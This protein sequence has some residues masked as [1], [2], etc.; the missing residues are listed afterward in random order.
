M[1]KLICFLGITLL[2]TLITACGSNKGDDKGPEEI[3]VKWVN[4]EIQ[5]DQSKMLELLAEKT[6]ALDSEKKS[7]SKDTIK[8]YKLTEWKVNEKDY[9]YEVKYQNPTKG[10]QL[11]IEKMEVIKTKNGWK[12][13][14]YGDINN[15]DSL[16]EDLKPKILRELHGE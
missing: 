3:P 6:G 14:K 7:T 2:L 10:N 15:F 13:T 4:A 12:R 8:N 1:K 5:K 9:F 16:V 11:K